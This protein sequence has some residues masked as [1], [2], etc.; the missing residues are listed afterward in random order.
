MIIAVIPARGGSK[1]VPNKNLRQLNGMSLV[2]RAT[3][4]AL[5]NEL[6]DVTVVST[7]RVEVVSDLLGAN[8]EVFF[9]EMQQGS[10]KIINDQFYI[11]KRREQHATDSS[12]TVET[13][14]DIISAAKLRD[15]DF[16]LL[17]QPTTPFRETEEV[18]LL[19][20]LSRRN[21]LKSIV[22][23]KLFDS[24]HPSKAFQLGE[25]GTLNLEILD[26]LSR[27]RQELEKL[28]IF[29]GAYYLTEVASI[30]LNSSLLTHKNGI[31]IREGL[32]TLNIDNEDD[33][34][35]AEFLANH[36]FG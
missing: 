11:H 6:V 36:Y 32:K 17:L 16:I 28:Y 14:L 19:V 10:M 7:D 9:Q 13:V 3:N 1:G 24:P 2:K 5:E 15:E 18:Q 8:A 25:D 26:R 34:K 20:E 29:D 33:M 30:R 4:F 27:P 31:F 21:E 22:S 12:R 23:A 35:F